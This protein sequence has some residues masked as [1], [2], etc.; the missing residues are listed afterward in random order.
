[1]QVVAKHGVYRLGGGQI[2]QRH[3]HGNQHQERGDQEVSRTAAGVEQAQF[4]EVVWP[5]LES[6]RGGRAFFGLAKV[7][8]LHRTPLIRVSADPPRPQRVVQQELHHVGLGEE[9]CH[10][11]QLAGADLDLGPVDLVLLPGLPELVDPA[12]RIAR[13]EQVRGK[14]F[15]QTFQLQTMLPREPDL[16]HRMVRS[17]H[18]RQQAVG[19]AR[20]ERPLVDTLLA[21]QLLAFVQ[22]DGNPHLRFDEQIVLGEK[23]REQHA[24]PILVGALVHQEAGRLTS[25]ARIEAITELAGMDSEPPSQGALRRA[26][27]SVGLVVMHGES[28]QGDVRGGLGHVPGF[29]DRPFELPS[30]VW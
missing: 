25:R 20:G 13:P 4:R 24:V 30:Q 1:M 26:H 9:L 10:R 16:E 21:G 22:G 28:L 8:Q 2:L 12:E 11:R 14:I 29:G 19:E 18:L 23:A 3:A 27:V 17:E 7:G 6:A 15:D 5:A